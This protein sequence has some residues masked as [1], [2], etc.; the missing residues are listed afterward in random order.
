V[1]NMR[2]VA[3]Y[4]GNSVRTD[5]TCIHAYPVCAIVVRSTSHCSSSHDG[6]VASCVVY[7]CWFTPALAHKI[8]VPPFRALVEP[9]PYSRTNPF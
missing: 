3:L 7:A 1:P 5:R 4:V 9:P 6:T 8:F 2:T